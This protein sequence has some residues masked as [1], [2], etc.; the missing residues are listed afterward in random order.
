MASAGP[1]SGILPDDRSHRGTRS[2][3]SARPA[4]PGRTWMREPWAPATSVTI[5]S[6]GSPS[7]ATIEPLLAHLGRRAPA[8]PAARSSRRPRRRRT[9]GG[10]RRGGRAGRG[11]WARTS[12]TAIGHALAMTRVGC[13]G[14]RGAGRDA[15]GRRRRGS[16]RGHDRRGAAMVP[17][18]RPPVLGRDGRSRHR[19]LPPAPVPRGAGGPRSASPGSPSATA[20]AASSSA[21]PPPS[22]SPWPAGRPGTSTSRS[23]SARPSAGSCGPWAPTSTAACA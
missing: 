3:S 4:P 22:R 9:R 19:R 17:R 8:R 2:R 13:R 14:R 20:H 16:R 15:A 5:P 11:R 18:R 21:T 7:T 23:A 12:V 10:S 1:R 6:T